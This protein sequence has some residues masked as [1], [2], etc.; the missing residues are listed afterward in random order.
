MKGGGACW[1]LQLTDSTAVEENRNVLNVLLMTCKTHHRTP[2][3]NPP[4]E[5]HH[6]TV[7]PRRRRLGLGTGTP[8]W[9][10]LIVVFDEM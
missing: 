10:V 8:D 7:A 3:Q 4:T 9:S 2:P 1:R 5:A 6:R